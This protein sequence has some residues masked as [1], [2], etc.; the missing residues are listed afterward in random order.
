[1]VSAT[2]FEIQRCLAQEK[3]QVSS[4]ILYNQ[5]G[6]LFALFLHPSSHIGVEVCSR[7]RI[8]TLESP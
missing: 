4:L 1:M 3:I 2:R 7:S 6:A 8:R 5:A